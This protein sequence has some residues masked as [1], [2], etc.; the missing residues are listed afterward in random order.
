MTATV[1]D[2]HD[3]LPRSDR[4]AVN[5]LCAKIVALMSVVVAA[6][7]FVG[8]LLASPPTRPAWAGGV[9]LANADADYFPT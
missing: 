1:K 5:L 4:H 2:Y 3:R 9:M 7:W 8:G 6:V